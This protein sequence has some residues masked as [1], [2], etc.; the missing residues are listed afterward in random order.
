[1]HGGD[2]RFDAWTQAMVHE[3]KVVNYTGQSSKPLAPIK[4]LEARVRLGIITPRFT[5]DASLPTLWRNSGLACPK[6]FQPP[7]CN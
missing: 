6:R 2:S 4:A 7:K 3:G 5:T 1:M